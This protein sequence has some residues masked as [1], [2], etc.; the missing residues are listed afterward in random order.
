[1]AR[2]RSVR[3]GPS[4]IT[5]ERVRE[6]L[7]ELGITIGNRN[8]YGEYRVN[9]KGAGEGPAYY[10]DS[11]DDALGT[12]KHMAAHVAKHGYVKG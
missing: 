12:G 4:K 7:R 10:T 11:L 3:I 8:E 5:L 1:M 9:L 2:H 6:I